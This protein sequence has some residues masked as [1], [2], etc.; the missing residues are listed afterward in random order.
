MTKFNH[1]PNCGKRP[2]KGLLGNAESID[3]YECKADGTKYCGKH[4][5]DRCPNCG[6]KE[7]KKIGYCSSG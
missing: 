3:I 6:A 1:C 4:C 7:R 2:Q 5:G